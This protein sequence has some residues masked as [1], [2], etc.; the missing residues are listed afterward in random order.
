MLGERNLVAKEQ[1]QREISVQYVKDCITMVKELDGYEISRMISDDLPRE[2]IRQIKFEDDI[3]ALFKC[4]DVYVHVPVD[5]SVEAFGQ[6]YVEALLSGVPSVFTLS[7]IAPEFIENDH[8]AMVVPFED[9]V[10]IVQSVIRLRENQD[11]ATTLVANGRNSASRFDF[12]SYCKH[13]VAYSITRASLE[14]AF[15][16]LV[17]SYRNAWLRNLNFAVHSI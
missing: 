11:L 9:S 5:P 16:F 3:Y 4:F 17:N 14:L 12:D 13:C 15:E 2:S 6:T 8:N 7:G 10:S 1:A